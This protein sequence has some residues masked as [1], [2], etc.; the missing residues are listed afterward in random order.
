[1]RES[2]LRALE[3]VLEK[4][5]KFGHR[6]HLELAWTY[7]ERYP[8]AA[9]KQAMAAAIRYLAREHEQAAKYHQTMTLA[10]VHLVAVH[11]QRS[12][13]D[14]FDEF[15]ARNPQLLSRQLLDEHYSPQLL[16]SE[17]ARAGWIEPD[18]RGLPALAREPHSCV[19]GASAV[20]S[21]RRRRRARTG[22]LSRPR[23]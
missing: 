18:L 10:W 15:I 20:R 12:P 1:M 2:D 21:A 4:A 14:G 22:P 6:E 19:S 23:A 8:L 9:A 16:W 13:A 3:V 5:Q 7:L 17:S 11:R